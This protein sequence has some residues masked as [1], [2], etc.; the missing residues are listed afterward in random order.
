[1]TTRRRFGRRRGLRQHGADQEAGNGGGA[2]Q[3]QGAF[4]EEEAAIDL[5]GGSLVTNPGDEDLSPGTP[6]Y[7]RR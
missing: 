7:Q 1:M 2:G 6:V 3:R 4:V 5:H